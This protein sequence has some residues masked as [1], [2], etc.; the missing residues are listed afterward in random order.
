LWDKV[1]YPTWTRLA[2][3]LASG[4]PREIFE[5][6]DQL[7]QVASS[8]IEAIL[9]G[10]ATAL[11][12]VVDLGRHQRLLDIGSGTGSW[13]I[14]IAQRHQHLEGAVLELPIT[15][16]R[17]PANPDRRRSGMI[18]GPRPRLGWRATAP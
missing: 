8:G 6:D 4:P 2:E 18:A 14:A 10:P 7:Q 13:S 9:A 15:A 3:A 16:P 1:S 11:P 12:Q 5:R 17:R